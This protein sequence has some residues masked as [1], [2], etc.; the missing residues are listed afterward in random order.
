MRAETPEE[1]RERMY[2]FA[3]PGH[4]VPPP[5]DLEDEARITPTDRALAARFWARY[6]TPLLRKLLAAMREKPNG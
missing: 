3:Y 4:S 1:Q 2:R 5:T 6:G